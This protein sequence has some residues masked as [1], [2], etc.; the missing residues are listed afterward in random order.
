MHK[1]GRPVLVGTTSVEKSEALAALLDEEQIPYEVTRCAHAAPTLRQP[2]QPA[3][4]QR[5]PGARWLPCPAPPCTPPACS[6]LPLALPRTIS[7]ARPPFLPPAAAERQAGERGAG[8][9]DCGAERAARRRHHRDQ[10]GGPRY[11]HSAGWKPWWVSQAGGC[12]RWCCQRASLLLPL[13]PLLLCYS[14]LPPSYQPALPSPPAE[15]T[16]RLKLRGL[17]PLRLPLPPQLTTVTPPAGWPPVL[18]SSWP[19]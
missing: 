2:R 4:R 13:P 15:F 11:R 14:R 19:A 18:Q 5:G 9:R 12:R 17:L 6:P 8:E 7:C 1:T 10:H 3:H 16:A